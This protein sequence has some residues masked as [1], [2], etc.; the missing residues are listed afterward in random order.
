MPRFP[1]GS[2]SC[3]KTLSPYISRAFLTSFLSKMSL[4]CFTPA[5]GLQK[6]E[7]IEGHWTPQGE[8][9]TVDQNVLALSPWCPSCWN[10]MRQN[11]PIVGLATINTTMITLDWEQIKKKK[12]ST[13]QIILVGLSHVDSRWFNSPRQFYRLLRPLVILL[14]LV[15]QVITTVILF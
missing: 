5:E 11:K 8:W 12:K 10:K 9:A 4:D 3:K 15:V 13:T 2:E 6:L 7:E 14:N 1:K